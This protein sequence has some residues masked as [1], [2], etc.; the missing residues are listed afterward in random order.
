MNLL[1]LTPLAQVGN[2]FRAFP[3]RAGELQASLNARSCGLHC[4][5]RIPNAGRGRLEEV[6]ALG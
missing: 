6:P 1:L 3:L 2:N 5:L 4:T